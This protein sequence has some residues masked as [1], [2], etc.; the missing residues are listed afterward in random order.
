[1]KNPVTS[2]TTG[3]KIRIVWKSGR[4]VSGFFPS[5]PPSFQGKIKFSVT[6]GVEGEDRVG[7]DRQKTYAYYANKSS[8]ELMALILFFHNTTSNIVGFET[9]V[10][11]LLEDDFIRQRRIIP[12]N[13]TST[14]G[15]TSRVYRRS[16]HHHST[17]TKTGIS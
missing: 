13:A 8:R 5:V 14:L 17:A 11:P 15:N 9:R 16:M 3:T 12:G 7:G 4:R 2:E 1:M 10:C 6:I